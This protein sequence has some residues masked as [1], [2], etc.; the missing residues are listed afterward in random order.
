VKAPLPRPVVWRLHP[1]DAAEFAAKGKHCEHRGCRDPQ[2]VNTWRYWRSTEVGR[3]LLA[4]HQ[5]CDQHG[6]EF[7]TRHHIEIQ[8]PPDEPEPEPGIR[9]RHAGNTE[10]TR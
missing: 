10:G 1:D 3:V 6:Q 4:E 8:P 5:V 7:A 2:A 9:S